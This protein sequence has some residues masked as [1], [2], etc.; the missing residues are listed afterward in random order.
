MRAFGDVVV[1]SQLKRLD[2]VRFAVPPAEDDDGDLGPVFAE[3][4]EQRP[5]VDARQLKLEEEDVR[6]LRR[7]QRAGFG[8]VARLDRA[9]AAAREDAAE[10]TLHLGLVVDDEDAH[11]WSARSALNRRRWRR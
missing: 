3:L 10:E 4:A 8:R 7:R 1:C 11:P 6:F 9:I 5:S 2:L